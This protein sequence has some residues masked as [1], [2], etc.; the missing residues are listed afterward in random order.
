MDNGMY[1]LAESINE[2]I[3]T[4]GVQPVV[5]EET[6]ETFIPFTSN[7]KHYVEITDTSGTIILKSAQL[8]N[9]IIPFSKEQLTE[10]LK[11]NRLYRTL[12]VSD[13]D[14]LWDDYGLRML[15]CPI[16]YESKSYIIMV[17][18]P[19]SNLILKMQ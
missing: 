5:L 9:F 13:N 10:A 17:A 15:F 2:E 1:V 19:M 6:K 12:K 16:K 14:S 7:T 18:V 3:Q 8:G 11:S 4:E